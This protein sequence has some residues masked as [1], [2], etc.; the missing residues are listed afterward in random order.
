M[1]KKQSHG[2]TPVGCLTAIEILQNEMKENHPIE[3]E[4]E[5]A[6]WI[7]A[8]DMAKRLVDCPSIFGSTSSFGV[9]IAMTNNPLL[10]NEYTH[11]LLVVSHLAGLSVAHDFIF[12]NGFVEA[13]EGLLL[14]SWPGVAHRMIFS[15]ETRTIYIFSKNPGGIRGLLYK[16]I[17]GYP[18][19]KEIRDKIMEAV[20]GQYFLKFEIVVSG[21]VVYAKAKP[22]T[23]GSEKT[24][25]FENEI[26]NIAWRASGNV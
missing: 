8:Y 18:S 25:G 12:G 10:F 21:N 26:I 19:A 16:V 5:S 6:G 23:C 7:F 17:F 4:R 13:L 15:E 2:F 3:Y 20:D 11:G 9:L 1:R 24:A 22:F 14:L